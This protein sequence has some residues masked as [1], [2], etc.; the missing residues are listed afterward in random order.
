MSKIKGKENALNEIFKIEK[1]LIGT[2]H[3]LPYPGSPHYK[4]EDINK[5]IQHAVDEA[6]N[7]EKGGMDGIIIENEGD[8]PFLRPDDL[9]FETASMA[10]V[11][12]YAVS[13]L[14]DIPIGINILANAAVASLA[15]AKTAGASFVRVKSVG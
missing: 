9:G 3:C 4:N 6:I 12:T 2:V 14:I 13:Q 11:I 1:P 10:A 8:F 15:A 7:Y 5:I